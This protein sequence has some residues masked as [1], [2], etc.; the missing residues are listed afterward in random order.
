MGKYSFI[1]ASTSFIILLNI[2]VTSFPAEVQTLTGLNTTSIQ[3]STQVDAQINANQTS[4]TNVVDQSGSIVDVYTNPSTEN[5]FLG[6]IFTLY[7]IAVI[8]LLIDILW[9]G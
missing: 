1:I 8:V 7:I 3:S 5:R 4:Q 6:A 2:V 9:V